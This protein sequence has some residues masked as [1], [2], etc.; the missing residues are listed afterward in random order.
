MM[1]TFNPQNVKCLSNNLFIEVYREEGLTIKTNDGQIKKLTN[2]NNK[3]EQY[4]KVHA[5]GEEIKTIKPGDF[6]LLKPTQSG[7]L[8]I[9]GVEYVFLPA[10]QVN[11]VIQEQ[12]LH[13]FSNKN[14]KEEKPS[15]NFLDA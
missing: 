14:M 11:A 4:A 8:L 10:Y 2:L 9:E 3:P 1:K 12:D 15:S 13:F 6:V 7:V 5:V